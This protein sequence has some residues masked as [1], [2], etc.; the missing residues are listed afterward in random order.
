[1]RR[2]A[3]DGP[4]APE[5]AAR[6]RRGGAALGAVLAA[7]IACGAPEAVGAQVKASEA[8]TMS[9]TIDG[10]VIDMAFSRPA[11]RDRSPLFGGVVHWGERWTPGANRA[12]TLSVS[13]DVELAGVPVAAGAYS[14]WMDVAEGGPWTLVLEP[15]T[16]LYHTQPPDDADDQVRVAF[17]PETSTSSMDALLW[18]FAS[19]R[20]DGGDL[21]MHWGTTVASFDLRVEPTMTFTVA[22]EEAALVTGHWT[23]AWL[24]RD[25]SE[26]APWTLDLRYDEASGL[27][28]GDMSGGGDGTQLYFVPRAE[29]IY[30]WGWGVEGSVWEVTEFMF[31]FDA[32]DGRTATTFEGRTGPEDRLVARGRRASPPAG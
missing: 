6:G 27:L 16:A 14:V 9:Q 12:T 26:G 20:A 1:M 18:Y 24:R 2:P 15:D 25:G 30:A 21:R 8:A 4:G 31:E 11:A 23:G 13:K 29:G 3:G 7:C 28:L 22:P 32:V 10:T 5:A 17:E 19:V